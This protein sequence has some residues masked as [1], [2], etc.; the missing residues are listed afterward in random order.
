MAAFVSLVPEADRDRLVESY[1]H[2]LTSGDHESAVKAAQAWTV[3]EDA[4]VMVDDQPLPLTE[5]SSALSCARIEC[6]Y[7]IHD[8]FF[9]EETTS[10]TISMGSQIFHAA[11]CRVSWIFAARLIRQLS[12]RSTT[13]ELNCIWSKRVR[14]G[15]VTQPLPAN[16]YRQ[17]T[18][19]ALCINPP[20]TDGCR[21]QHKRPRSSTDLHVSPV[22]R[23]ALR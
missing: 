22:Q 1:Y 12:W 23:C 21:A 6:H 7:M 16:W 8:L 19:T 9:N 17:R 14:T 11:L 15:R 5:P 20:K 2:L 4:L 18:I 3:W 10:S 13:R